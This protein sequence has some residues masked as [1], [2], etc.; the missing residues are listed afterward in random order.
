MFELSIAAAVARQGLK[1]VLNLDKPDLEFQFEGRRVL[2]E[3]KRV[4]SEN[5]INE[6]DIGRHS[7]ATEKSECVGGSAPQSIDDDFSVNVRR[8]P[9][10]HILLQIRREHRC[11]QPLLIAPVP[12]LHWARNSL[13]YDAPELDRING[14]LKA[15]GR[16]DLVRR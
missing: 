1:P 4:L 5:G 15:N 9:R 16:T 2:M 3:C 8:S 7:P 11:F 12:F 6:S 14:A 10:R 13:R